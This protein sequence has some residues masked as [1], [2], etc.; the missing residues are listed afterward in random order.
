MAMKR[1]VE[2]AVRLRPPNKAE[3][4]SSPCLQHDDQTITVA[5]PSA[6]LQ[7]QT[8]AFDRVYGH[9]E[10]QAEVYGESVG[11]LVDAVLQG[12]G[13]V[14]FAY[15]Q[16]GSGKTH[17]MLGEVVGAQILEQTGV[18]LRVV[19]DLLAVRRQRTD[20]ADVFDIAFSAME[21]YNDEP[22]DLLNQRAALK[23]QD[24]GEPLAITTR[25][26]ADL[27]DAVTGYKIAEASRSA[28]STKMNARS[29]RSHALFTLYVTQSV[30]DAKTGGKKQRTARLSVVDLAG[31]ERIKKSGVTGAALEEAKH[32]NKSL[33]SLGKVMHDL[34]SGRGHVSF[35]DCKLTRLL[36][37]CFVDP[38]SKVVLI[39]ATS[40]SEVQCAETLSSLRFANCVKT[41]KAKAMKVGAAP[42]EEQIYLD[43]CKVFDQLSA[44]VRIADASVAG[45]HP[46]QGKKGSA[47]ACQA[48]VQA[49]AEERAR[50][51]EAELQRMMADAVAGAKRGFEEQVA[52]AE[53]KA[54]AADVANAALAEKIDADAEEH[55]RDMAPVAAALDTAKAAKEM[56]KAD[57]QARRGERDALVGDGKSLADQIEAKL[58]AEAALM[59]DVKEEDRAWEACTADHEDLARVVEE[60]ARLLAT[61]KADLI[62]RQQETLRVSWQTVAELVET[63]R[64][65]QK[66]RADTVAAEEA[67]VPMRPLPDPSIPTVNDGPR[68]HSHRASR[69]SAASDMRDDVSLE[70]ASDVDDRV[71]EGTMATA[72]AGE[73]AFMEGPA[74]I[75][76]NMLK[77]VEEELAALLDPRTAAA[78]EG[79]MDSSSDA[80]S[81]EEEE[82]DESVSASSDAPDVPVDPNTSASKYQVMRGLPAAAT[83]TST[84]S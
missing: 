6:G 66:E 41:I 43:M 51:D 72:V 82:T 36:Q 44:D 31:S 47:A 77:E 76:E 59:N 12:G 14:V 61:R 9:E 83:K 27:D 5:V 20:P 34:N 19:A 49:R 39:V 67:H 10:T 1:A 56:A 57:R 79:L 50:C 48:A 2:V 55:T 21:V 70:T 38:K 75:L 25:P 68:R 32:I 11:D 52:R 53:E 15:G 69:A 37:P 26:V 62:A 30:V 74:D 22:R 42:D 84:Q 64:R 63:L 73:D 54:A 7:P 65:Q 71:S 23:L 28:S 80:T 46:F 4:Y 33:S 13:G 78:F 3:R 17:T 24:N 29:S 18:Y 16:T 40:P 58:A 60:G 8:F 45:G 35:R 81:D